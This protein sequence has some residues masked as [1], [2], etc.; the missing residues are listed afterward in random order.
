MSEYILS[1]I[2]LKKSQLT[3]MSKKSETSPDLYVIN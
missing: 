2:I 1:S 3:R